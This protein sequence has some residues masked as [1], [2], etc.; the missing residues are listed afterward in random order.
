MTDTILKQPDGRWCVFSTVIEAFVLEDATRTE[1]REFLLDKER[2]RIDDVLND[3]ESGERPSKWTYEKAVE[4][5][6]HG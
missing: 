6:E 2:D 1:V 4:R 3:V 5:A